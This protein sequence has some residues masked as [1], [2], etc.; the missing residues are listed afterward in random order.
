[1]PL[2]LGEDPGRRATSW[3]RDQGRS[4]SPMVR[5]PQKFHLE[6]EGGGGCNQLSMRTCTVES[7]ENWMPPPH[8]EITHSN[9]KRP[10]R[11]KSQRPFRY[12]LHST[13]RTDVF[14]LLSSYC[15]FG[16]W[17]YTKAL[18]PPHCA[19]ECAPGVKQFWGDAF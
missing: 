7:L 1:M 19:G 2:R 9:N 13:R 10:L 5:F 11:Q 6:T 15:T 18:C 17:R 8:L 12:I 4:S 16:F 14:W 3:S